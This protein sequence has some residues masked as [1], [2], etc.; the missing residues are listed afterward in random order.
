MRRQTSKLAG[1]GRMLRRLFKLLF[2]LAVLAGLFLVAYA[3]S[4]L[5]QPQTREMILPVELDGD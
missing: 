2:V 5:M 4:G 3:Y 1:W